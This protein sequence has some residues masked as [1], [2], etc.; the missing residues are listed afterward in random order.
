[1]YKTLLEFFYVVERH[2]IVV[3]IVYDVIIFLVFFKL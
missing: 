1:M 3:D 2:C